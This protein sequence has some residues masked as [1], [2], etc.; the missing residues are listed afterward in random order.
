MRTTDTL[1]I[2]AGPGGLAVAGR[3]RKLGRDFEVIEKTDKIA[4]S[5]HNHY[6][7]LCLHTVKQLSHLPHLAFPEHYPTY[8][9]REDLVRYYESYAEEFQI[10]PH[11]NQEADIV[12]KQGDGFL[13][14]SKGGMS[15][16]VNNVVVASGVNRVP[17]SPSWEGQGAFE[18]EITHSRDYKNPL[19]FVGKK[20]LVIGFGNTGA[21]LALDLA[22]QDVDVA[23][24]L[25]S[26]IT[27]VPRDVNGRPVQLTARTLAKLPFGLGDW[28]GTQVRKAVIGDLSKYG[29]PMSNVHPAVQLRETGKTPVI[30]LGTVN[31]IKNGR[32]KILK[33]VKQFHSKGVELVNGEKHDFDVILLCTG[34]KAKVEEFVPWI[35]PFLDKYNVPKGPIG[36]GE[37]K[38]LYFV[39][40][41]NY[42]LGGILG[43]IFNDSETIAKDIALQSTSEKVS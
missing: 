39:G 35:G 12:E 32:I 15:F 26:P 31:Y 7:R 42:K 40:F 41:D 16:Q 25:R 4:W 27:I 43:T 11:F 23:A 6:D 38:G 28:L 17:F 18:G 34:Y 13:V 9:P 5:W 33:D 22:E 14:K 8:V 3:L 2:G 10:S 1:I 36:T 29:V 20:V 21:E 19:P 24:S 37:H 30:D